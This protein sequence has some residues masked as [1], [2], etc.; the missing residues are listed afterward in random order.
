MRDFG[1]ECDN[2]TCTHEL[3]KVPIASLDQ[4]NHVEFAREL[5]D[6]EVAEF[7][8]LWLNTSSATV[9]QLSLLMMRARSNETSMIIWRSLNRLQAW[10][11]DQLGIED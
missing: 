9:Q 7:L 6:D 4:L 8:Q 3:N 11:C 5:T 2:H 10:S 1:D